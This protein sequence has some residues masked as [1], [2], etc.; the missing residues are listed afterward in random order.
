MTVSCKRVLVDG[1]LTPQTLEI[2]GQRIESIEA[3]HGRCDRDFGSLLLLPGIVDLHGDAFER[4]WMPRPGV[5]F[6]IEMAL[7]ETD[8]QL[9]ANGITTAYHSL[10]VSWEPGLRGL[11]HGQAMIDALD[12]IRPHLRS[13]TRLHLRYEVFAL[14][15]VD[16]MKAW[17]RN[18]KVDLIGFNDHL[19]MIEERLSNQDR[20]GTYAERSGLSIG[21]FRALLLLTKQRAGEVRGGVEQVAAL[22]RERKIP[23][24]SHDD[25]TPAMRATY[26]E[27]GA[28]ICEFPLDEFTARSAMHAG[29]EVVMGSPNVVRG[30]SHAKRMTA[31]SA[32]RGGFCTIL[33]SDYFYPSILYAAFRIEE[34]GVLPLPAAWKLVSENPARAAGLNDRGRIAPGMRADLLAVDDS[35]PGHPRIAATISGGEIVYCAEPSMLGTN[36]NELTTH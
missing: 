25:E 31:M 15:Q 6:P 16:R 1:E 8:R 29:G 34:D 2:R 12:A 23:M 36:L 35:I 28:G 3:G 5:F 20:A 7:L 24:A 26:A 13:D 18:A 33:T 9:L 21:G 27:L 4:Q 30:A 10:T 32:I 22:A 14:D 11:E 19:Q 17:I